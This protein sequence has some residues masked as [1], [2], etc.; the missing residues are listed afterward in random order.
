MRLYLLHFYEADFESCTHSVIGACKALDLAVAKLRE[1]IAETFE[2]NKEWW[3]DEEDENAINEQ[4]QEWIAE[5]YMDDEHLAWSYTDDDCVEY[6]FKI[7]AAEIESDSLS[8]EAFAVL[9]TCIDGVDNRTELVGVYTSQEDADKALETYQS[10]AQC[11]EDED[12]FIENV[13][14]VERFTVE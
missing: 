3:E 7:V 2:G 6:L 4:Y 14:T 8:Q 11:E 1:H 12:C 5:N 13:V 10:E 9:H